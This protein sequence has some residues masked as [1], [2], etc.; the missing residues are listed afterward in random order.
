[1]GINKDLKEIEKHWNKRIAIVL[2]GV[3]ILVIGLSATLIRF[4]L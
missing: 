3:A 4:L 2:I 1:M